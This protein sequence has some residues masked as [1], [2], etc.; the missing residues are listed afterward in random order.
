MI[1]SAAY[2]KDKARKDSREQRE[3][4]AKASREDGNSNAQAGR[5]K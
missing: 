1:L 3:G 5:T 2:E 4:K